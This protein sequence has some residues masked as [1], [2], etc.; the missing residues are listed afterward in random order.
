M[1]SPKRLGL[2]P[3]ALAAVLVAGCG[4]SGGSS[5]SSPSATEW[6]NSLCSAITTWSTS[7]QASAQTLQGGN[8]SA[9][10]LK[11]EIGRVHV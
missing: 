2:I 11:T 4:G 6:A 9:D 8:L 7:V 5:S 3:V 10:S 1:V